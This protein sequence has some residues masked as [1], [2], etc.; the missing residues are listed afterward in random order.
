MDI[1]AR[2]S[3]FATM[4]KSDYTESQENKVKITD[5][6]FEV[7]KFGIKRCYFNVEFNTLVMENNILLLQ[8]FEKYGMEDFKKELENYSIKETT[9]S[10]V[11]SIVNCSLFENS[12]RLE[13]YCTYFLLKCIKNST[14]V[15]NYASLN[16]EFAISLLGKSLSTCNS[17]TTK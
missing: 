7:V 1:A 10:N 6:P 16:N 15:P 4:F 5:F 12:Q 14:P 3:V 2:F 8:F 17:F 13:S 9:T 11:C